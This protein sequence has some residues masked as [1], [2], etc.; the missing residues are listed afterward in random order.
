MVLVGPSLGAA[1][2]IDIAVNYPEMVLNIKELSYFPINKFIS[3]HVQKRLTMVRNMN[4]QVESLVLM[5]A[6]VY[7]E[8]TGNL[9]TLPKAAAY[10]GVSSHHI[11]C[12][13]IPRLC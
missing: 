11:L 2:A 1:V 4:I 9:A 7:A 3:K 10:A 13:Q 5:D 12:I 6:S 8:G